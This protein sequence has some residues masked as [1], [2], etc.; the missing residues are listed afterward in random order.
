MRN[1]G[2]LSSVLCVYEMCIGT[3]RVVVSVSGVYQG[4]FEV[5]LKCCFM[6]VS[7]LKRCTQCLGG[8]H[9][10]LRFRSPTYYSGSLR[11]IY[12]DYHGMTLDVV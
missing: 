9:V 7:R 5:F 10:T 6:Y 11:L 8:L 4:V 2:T 1:A 3:H 12:N